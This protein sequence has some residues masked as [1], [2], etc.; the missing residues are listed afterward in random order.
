MIWLFLLK[1]K[2][3]AQIYFS[4]AHNVWWQRV[5]TQAPS[6]HTWKLVFEHVWRMHENVCFKDSRCIT[7]H[8]IQCVTQQCTINMLW[9]FATWSQPFGDLFQIL[10]FDPSPHSATCIFTSYGGV[11]VFVLYWLLLVNLQV[12]V[13]IL[14]EK[15]LCLCCLLYF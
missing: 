1:K 9:I 3:T 10:A 14:A 7:Q 13:N 5:A 8:Y 12:I 6:W 11:W 2:D 15:V 4:L